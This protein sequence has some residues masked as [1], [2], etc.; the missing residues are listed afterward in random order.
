[1]IK[2]YHVHE[3]LLFRKP[4]AVNQLAEF[5]VL[6]ENVQ[7]SKTG[8]EM[9]LVLQALFVIELHFYVILECTFLYQVHI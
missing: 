7:L 9:L 8:W 6:Y 5:R 2:Y 4:Q 1:M 3:S